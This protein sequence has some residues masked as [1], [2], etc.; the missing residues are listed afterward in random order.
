[1]ASH[2]GVEF[3]DADGAY[4]RKGHTGCAV[5]IVLLCLVLAAA[6]VAGFFGY[7]LYKSAKVVQDDARVVMSSVDT[8]KDSVM[9][10]NS[11][12]LQQSAATISTNAHAIHD[13][14]NTS[15]WRYASLIPKYGEDIKSVQVL[16]DVLVDL[17]DN[18]LTPIASSSEVMNL[19]NL[20]SDGSINVA[21][22]QSLS[23]TLDAALP[24]ISRSAE[25]VDAL[26]EANV[27]RVNDILAK[28][29]DKLV[30]GDEMLRKVQEVL[31]YVPA[32]L[33]ADGQTRNYL[34]IAQNNAEA[35]SLGGL[36]GSWGVVSITDGH[37]S[38]GD[39]TTI[40][41]QDGLQVDGTEE[42]HAFF[43][44]NFDTNPA[45]VNVLCDF[46]RVG[47]LSQQ[48]WMQA[49][50]Q[51]VNGVIALDPIFLQHMIGLTGSIEV[52]DGSVLDGNNTAWRLLS[53]VYWRYGY[54]SNEQDYYFAEVAGLAAKSFFNNIGNASITELG[55]TVFQ[56]IGD[57][58]IYAWME[59]ADEE[60]IVESFGM[61]GKVKSDPTQP[62]LGI[63]VDDDTY[64]K[65]SWYLN[66]DIAVGD[67][68]KNEDG[69]T[70]YDVKV[71]FTN[72]MTP[73]DS[74]VSP[75]YVHGGNAYKRSMGDMLYFIH[76]L[77][78]AGGSIE[79]LTSE[80]ADWITDGWVYGVQAKRS[81]TH[82]DC[83]EST[84]YTMRVVVPAEATEPLTVR[85]TPLA[86]EDAL[87]I[88]Y[89]WEQ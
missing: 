81:Y 60:R 75:L 57:H 76:F 31:P 34:I 42:E 55:K 2:S 69:T 43:A 33:G 72:I 29:K 63:Y 39:F 24:V 66:T 51:W 41:H 89:A 19:S 12:A 77:A 46:S 38:L 8:I 26:P 83:L 68:V 15:L 84:T 23:G 32:M 14:V 50:G 78:P 58:R 67:G 59:N 28:V 36:P 64:S 70:S 71:V 44:T 40:L 86:R 22:L 45:Q 87:T 21:A 85:T 25:A 1:M 52:Y 35:R 7:R 47:V 61:D 56:L 65:M 10:G 74:W 37:I 49:T 27:D 17:S 79:D 30:T 16:A 3:Y 11:E 4:E 5:L 53:D 18:A 54:D 48:Y 9:S 20:L 88:T 13:E 6:G 73:E 62:E 80:E 82:T